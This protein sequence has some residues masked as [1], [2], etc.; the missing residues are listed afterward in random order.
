[1]LSLI[2]SHLHLRPALVSGIS[3]ITPETVIPT[4][5]VSKS[6]CLLSCFVVAKMVALLL[7]P[8]SYA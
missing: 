8:R 6:Q 1:M 7:I 4:G 3:D 2:L 5:A